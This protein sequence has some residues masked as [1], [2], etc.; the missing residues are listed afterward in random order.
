MEEVKLRS[1]ARWNDLE[2]KALINSFYSLV[3][4]TAENHHRTFTAIKTRIFKL[5]F[6]DDYSRFHN[7]S[8]KKTTVDVGINC[9]MEEE[10]LAR[11]LYPGYY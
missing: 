2:E 8:K 5:F 1:Y 9:D 7:K 6:K 4:N 10:M 3:V 11:E